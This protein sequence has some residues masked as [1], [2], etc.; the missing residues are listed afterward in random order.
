[1]K[2]E[3]FS[4]LKN[5]S[6]LANDGES[7]FLG[8]KNYFL[9]D[10]CVRL[11]RGVANSLS[12]CTPYLGMHAKLSIHPRGNPYSERGKDMIEKLEAV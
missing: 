2:V 12:N 8:K 6:V 1:L 10:L 9:I 5:F 11:K 7:S 3:K 4:F